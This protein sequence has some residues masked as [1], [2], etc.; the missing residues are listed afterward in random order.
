VDFKVSTLPSALSI[1]PRTRTVCAVAAAHDAAM[2]APA[3][4]N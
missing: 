1:V 4:A 2:I 3:S